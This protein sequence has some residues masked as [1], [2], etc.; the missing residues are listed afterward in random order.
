MNY[1][2]LQSY[3]TDLYINVSERTCCCASSH[4]LVISTWTMNVVMVNV[5]RIRD[6]KH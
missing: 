2:Y 5:P 4:R 6:N 3:L 1:R